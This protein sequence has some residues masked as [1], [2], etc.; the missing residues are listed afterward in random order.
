MP[1]F[2]INVLFFNFLVTIL[3]HHI[4]EFTKSNFHKDLGKAYKLFAKPMQ[5]KVVVSHPEPSDSLELQL[6]E[7]LDL[8]KINIFSE[9]GDARQE[10]VREAFGDSLKA[11]RV[12][13]RGRQLEGFEPAG[14]ERSELGVLRG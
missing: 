9:H 3:L 5:D 7:L 4:K 2:K 14:E 13:R 1:I 11:Q 12:A 6:D 8:R 10:F